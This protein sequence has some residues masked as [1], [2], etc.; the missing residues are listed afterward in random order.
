M[1]PHNREWFVPFMKLAWFEDL[2]SGVK[3]IYSLIALKCTFSS[4]GDE[5][6]SHLVIY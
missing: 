6:N 5:Q 3:H 4:N 2:D 1:C